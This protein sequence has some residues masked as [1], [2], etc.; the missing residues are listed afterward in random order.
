MAEGLRHSAALDYVDK[1][2]AGRAAARQLV[3]VYHCL[4]TYGL[5][6]VRRPV[7]VA[8]AYLERLLLV[9]AAA[10]VLAVPGEVVAHVASDLQLW[11]PLQNGGCLVGG[12]SQ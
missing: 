6:W 2:V 10:V 11:G 9:A 7:L 5:G 4:P 8:E 3:F 1:T 12:L